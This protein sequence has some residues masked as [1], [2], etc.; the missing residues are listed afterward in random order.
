MSFLSRVKTELCKLP[1]TQKCCA[2]AEAYGILLYCSTFSYG[3][4]R[5]ITESRAF[6]VRVRKLFKRAFE[7]E[8][9]SFPEKSARPGKLSLLIRDREKI[10]RIFENFG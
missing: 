4:I 8:F 10:G 6:A 7:L 2:A 1:I 9:D 5:I 3:E